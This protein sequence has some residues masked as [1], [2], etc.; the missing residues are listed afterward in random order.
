MNV[1]RRRRTK[2]LRRLVEARV[3]VASLQFHPLAFSMIWP[4]PKRFDV[5][6][7]TGV[8]RPRW[9]VEARGA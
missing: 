4:L 2:V 5:L 8:I 6:Y 3:R 9:P 7:G 1:S